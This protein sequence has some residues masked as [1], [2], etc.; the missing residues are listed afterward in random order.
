MISGPRYYSEHANS[1]FRDTEASSSRS[2][3]GRPPAL[4]MSRASSSS[5]ATEI[6]VPNTPRASPR[7]SFDILT[8]ASTLEV[9]ADASLEPTQGPKRRS[10]LARRLSKSTKKPPLDYQQT[11]AQA[12]LSNP[13]LHL[14]SDP[15]L[16]SDS[17]Q[18][19]RLIAFPVQA[20]APS[21]TS[22][23]IT[24]RKSATDWLKSKK[25]SAALIGRV[26]PPTTL[27]IKRSLARTSSRPGRP[28]ETGLTG[29]SPA[30]ALRTTVERMRAARTYLLEELGKLSVEQLGWDQERVSELSE[31]TMLI[32]DDTGVSDIATSKELWSFWACINSGVLL[33][34][35]VNHLK[36]GVI[37]RIDRRDIEWVRADNLSR[38]LRAARDFFAIRSRDLFHPLD[39]TEATVEGLE[40]AIHTILAIRDNA[41]EAGIS[42]S[43][44]SLPLSS[45]TIERVKSKRKSLVSPLRS[46]DESQ[47]DL[48]IVHQRFSMSS[49]SS[50][51][52]SLGEGSDS[53]PELTVAEHR[54]AAE[55]KLT[56][57]VSR[58]SDPISIKSHRSGSSQSSQPSSMMLHSTS[59]EQQRPRALT[60]T[61]AQDSTSPRW[62]AQDEPRVQS[63]YRDRKPSESAVNLRDVAE[64]E[65]EDVLQSG[66]ASSDSRPDGL[67]NAAE[68]GRV[69]SPGSEMHPARAPIIARTHSQHRISREIALAQQSPPH[70][71]KPRVHESEGTGSPAVERRH[72]GFSVG[73]SYSSE[74]SDLSQPDTSS[75]QSQVPFPS[76]RSPAGAIA[77][78]EVS[79]PS[80]RRP[81]LASRKAS[82]GAIPI[83]SSSAASFSARSDCLQGTPLATRTPVRPAFRPFRYTSELQ[84]PTTPPSFLHSDDA[85]SLAPSSDHR[86][87]SSRTTFQTRLS[88]DTAPS[89]IHSANSSSV[90]GRAV[91]LSAPSRH[92]ITL[93]EE[94]NK[95]TTFQMGNCIGRGQFGSVYRALNLSTGQMVAV[96][97]IKIEGRSEAEVTQLM[98]EVELLKRLH[99]PSVV[100]YEGLVRGT[101]AISIILE[102]VENGSLLHTLK[103]F[104][105]L[106]EQ[107]IA[108]YVVKI[109]E[110][111][112]YL[113]EMEVVHCDLKAANILTTKNG[114][115][116]LSDFGV[117]LNL[118]AMEKVQHNDAIGTPNWMAPEVIEL[119]GA[120]TAAD[121]WSLGCTIIELLTGKPPYGDMLAMSA[122]FRI[123]EDERP[124]IPDK[125]SE[126]LR[127][128]LGRCFRKDPK[129]RPHAADLFKHPWLASSFG[130]YK[131]AH[132]QDSLP[133]LKRISSDT[134]VARRGDVRTLHTISQ[135]GEES[136]VTG[137]TEGYFIQS[138][139]SLQKSRTSSG[140][141]GETWTP[142]REFSTS[143]S[144]AVSS[145][146]GDSGLLRSSTQDSNRKSDLSCLDLSSTD[147]SHTEHPP[148]SLERQSSRSP[149]PHKFVKSTFSRDI[150][151]KLC[152]QSVRK[153]AVF[154]EDCGLMCHAR[155]AR[156]IVSACDVRAQL[157]L[158][159]RQGQI[160]PPTSPVDLQEQE[161]L[162]N[163]QSA[164]SL[165]EVSMSEVASS[166]AGLFAARLKYAIARTRRISMGQRSDSFERR[167][168]SSPDASG[169]IEKDSPIMSI[170]TQIGASAAE[171]SSIA[172]ERT[173]DVKGE[174]EMGAEASSRKRA[175]CSSPG[176]EPRDSLPFNR[177]GSAE[178]TSV[179]PPPASQEQI[180][181]I[182]GPSRIQPARPR[183][184]HRVSHSTGDLITLQ[185]LNIVKEQ[186]LQKTARHVS[187]PPSASAHSGDP[188][189]GLA[190][191][192]L[193]SQRQRGQSEH[194]TAGP[195]TLGEKWRS[196]RASMG[197]RKKEECTVM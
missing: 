67:D 192:P 133:F 153:H 75:V 21:S 138:R 173:S 31:T 132:F 121:I 49:T 188:Y 15:L 100:K 161:A 117:S 61:F 197:P 10:A 4:S 123:V 19:R 108:S 127:D 124:P 78:R 63:V 114:N 163:H 86:T 118:Q 68:T 59:Q 166:A 171:S 12:T 156:E 107:L 53:H 60:I 150:R 109:L 189:S 70:I 87:S 182:Q 143:A 177:G 152:L 135:D 157:L 128:F 50:A 170:E 36:P 64:E 96:K 27:A 104:G 66:T 115:V 69:N 183:P 83:K 39:L 176:T 44:P 46:P 113:H 164:L 146:D 175:H 55:A 172:V 179:A 169:G 26:S 122:M 82:I 25:W 51:E 33:C 81:S 54:K 7:T 130:L 42:V 40:R 159:Q 168:A 180:A 91:S 112:V 158:L 134:G 74:A 126:E 3:Y 151:C 18:Y 190:Y 165:A 35:L 80:L 90:E 43:S 62:T 139:P 149:A 162:Q 184:T 17:L 97:R 145:A 79:G 155:C 13:E 71:W 194:T 23:C 41:T 5:L 142:A 147:D 98:K 73:Q 56:K 140:L 45:T 85:S 94:D 178:S 58:P 103:A 95:S 30:D 106:P 110:G 38:F 47:V 111:L 102:Y 101:D 84:V 11:L 187:P 119:Q 57:G 141:G 32:D 193:G 144:P 105:H 181:T 99:H 8:T 37:D 76:S 154:C 34:L 196:R 2:P 131:E 29:T 77:H 136:T 88:T 9:L 24:K 129:Q 116:K 92:K 191:T 14:S 174:T 160:E 65:A 89:E 52:L 1:P 48:P 125:C 137:P 20:D 195:S 93:L 6:A 167:G 185:G 22:P 148:Q 16:D 186:N 120:S 28:T 72:G